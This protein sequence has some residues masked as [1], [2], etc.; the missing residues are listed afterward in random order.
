MRFTAVKASIVIGAAAEIIE[1]KN[2]AE[3]VGL[4]V[5]KF[6]LSVCAVYLHAC[7]SILSSGHSTILIIL[8]KAKEEIEDIDLAELLLVT[9][10]FRRSFF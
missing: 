4:W 3:R 2:F 1:E 9:F 8:N 7:L 10:C 6:S 5:S